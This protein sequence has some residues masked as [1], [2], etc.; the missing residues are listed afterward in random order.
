ML[1]TV[2][3]EQSLSRHRA[4][5]NAALNFQYVRP[6]YSRQSVLVSGIRV[7]RLSSLAYRCAGVFSL[8]A[9][10]GAER[11]NYTPSMFAN[12]C[13]S[14]YTIIGKFYMCEIQTFGAPG[15]TSRPL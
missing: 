1:Y 11:G 9:E 12:D 10:C 4:S 5:L 14:R 3:S 15:G 8:D 7:C 6:V 2:P 13:V